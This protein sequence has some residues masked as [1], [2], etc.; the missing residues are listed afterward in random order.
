MNIKKLLVSASI[1][2]IFALVAVAGY[3][4]ALHKYAPAPAV[5]IAPTQASSSAQSSVPS[6]AAE[7][8][9]YCL[10]SQCWQENAKSLF[11]E[12]SEG[13]LNSIAPGETGLYIGPVVS[14][15]YFDDKWEETCAPLKQKVAELINGKTTVQDKVLSIANWV[16]KSRPYGA[17]PAGK[18]QDIC[19]LFSAN[20][21]ISADAAS[22][23]AAMLR[24]ARI[25]AR[26]VAPQTTDSGSPAHEY[27]SVFLDGKWVAIDST[28]GEGQR[29]IFE[30]TAILDSLTYSAFERP[31]EIIIASDNKFSR[32]FTYY[33]ADGIFTL[34]SVATD[35]ITDKGANKSAPHGTITYIKPWY[36]VF[37]L[38]TISKVALIAKDTQCDYFKCKAAPGVDTKIHLPEKYLIIRAQ[39]MLQVVNGGIA[40][41]IDNGFMAN[42][43]LRKD[44]YVIAGFPPGHYRFGYWSSSDKLVAYYDF[45]LK[46]SDNLTLK[47]DMLLKGDGANDAQFKGFIDY[48]NTVSK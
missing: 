40:Q 22:L 12:L 46:T 1:V 3:Y 24:Y 16:A 5:Q 28:F 35:L 43:D 10:G 4:F 45:E 41:E 33:L 34:T 27:T 6:G 13:A 17:L 44:Y 39:K 23:T 32:D 18:A 11:Q 31:R 9:N 2:L 42:D 47:P 7:I 19:E 8:I 20:S 14:R 21:G 48:L 25:P 37:G 29:N 15:V 38:D 26:V 30:P 36:S